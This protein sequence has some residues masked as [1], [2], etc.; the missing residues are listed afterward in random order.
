MKISFIGGGNMAAALIGGMLQQHFPAT[1]ISVVE[2]NAETRKRIKD[3]YNVIAVEDLA[4]GIADSNIVILAVK[5][6]QLYAVT[7]KIAPLLKSHLVISIVAGIQTRDI[8]RWL[9]GY[10]QIIRA[11]PNTPALVRA[12]VTGLFAL[13]EVN[14]EEKQ[15]AETILKAVG[16]VLWVEHEEQLD[17]VTAISGSGP[18]YV[19][20]FME[21]MQQA[22]KE[23]GLDDTQSYQLSIETFLG[24]AKLAKICKEKPSVLRGRVTSKNGTT[25]NAIKTMENDEI[26]K[27]IVRAIH[28][29]Y[30]RSRELGKE[31]GEKQ[32]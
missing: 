29:S 22:G 27:R 28:A 17:A 32:N 19:F 4:G 14:A 13:P 6:Q 21:A 5:P 2:I 25:E 16:T 24:S 11:M 18:A 31:L 9:N 8:Y 7:K 3:E 30:K 12:G 10:Q 26:N 20:Y 1:Q 15:N 23:L